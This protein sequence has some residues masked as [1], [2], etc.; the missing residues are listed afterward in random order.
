MHEEQKDVSVF[1][2]AK[3][4]SVC[5]LLVLAVFTIIEVIDWRINEKVSNPKFIREI[6]SNVRP[7]VI[8]NSKESIL[9]DMGAMQYINNIAVTQLPKSKYTKG[10]FKIIVSPK[11]YMALSPILSSIDRNE[12]WIETKR[13]KKFDWEYVLEWG[14]MVADTEK[15]VPPP[16]FR[17]EVMP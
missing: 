13:G 2:I 17:L 9:N 14:E 15:K 4:V 3:I 11:E 6:A 1:T 8:F 10:G 7:S 5:L 12:F 16:Q